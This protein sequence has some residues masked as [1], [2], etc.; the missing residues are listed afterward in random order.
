MEEVNR[1]PI[2]P[3]KGYVLK[4]ISPYRVVINL[5]KKKGVHRGMKFIIYEEGEMIY[6]PKNG[7]PVEKLELVKG[8]VEVIH[9]QEIMSVAESSPVPRRVYHSIPTITRTVEVKER[10]TTAPILQLKMDPVKA[11]DLVKQLI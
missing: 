8:T 4:V 9:L 3:K 10:L 11:G 1:M 6:D 5:G 2:A 7:K